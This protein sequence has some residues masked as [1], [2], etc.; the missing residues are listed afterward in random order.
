[1]SRYEVTLTDSDSALDIATK[2]AQ[3]MAHVHENAAPAMVMFRGKPYVAIVPPDAGL[4]WSR[5]E[6]SERLSEIATV[7]AGLKPGAVL[8]LSADGMV[9]TEYPPE[10]GPE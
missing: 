3:A 7:A 1:M 5:A 4:A 8:R 9:E 10:T 2:L 6:E